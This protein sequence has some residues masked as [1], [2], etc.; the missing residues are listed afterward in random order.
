MERQA[1]RAE[2]SERFGGGERADLGDRGQ[3]PV[4]ARLRRAPK[5]AAR[6]C[7]PGQG[8]SHVHIAA[9]LLM[10]VRERCAQDF[11]LALAALHWHCLLSS[12][13]TCPG[14]RHTA[15]G[16]ERESREREHRQA[17]FILRCL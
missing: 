13:N 11:G 9:H 2:R 16:R 10:S 17:G 1:R 15:C 14:C 3:A 12:V 8:S 4:Q 6:A 7:I 5:G